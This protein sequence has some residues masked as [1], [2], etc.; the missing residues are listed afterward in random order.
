MYFS[1]RTGRAPVESRLSLDRAFRQFDRAHLDSPVVR[2]QF[3]TLQAR[4]SSFCD[5]WDRGVRTREE[6]RGGPVARQSLATAV[7]PTNSEEL[8]YE[9]S[10]GFRRTS[11]AAT[12]DPGSAATHD[13]GPAATH[14][15]VRR[16]RM[17]RVR[18]A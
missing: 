7:P 6:G 10:F 11:P 9:A 1:G 17:T 16:L 2:F 8:L 3:A 5:L 18:R 13:P 4:Y 15:R 14:D 12:H